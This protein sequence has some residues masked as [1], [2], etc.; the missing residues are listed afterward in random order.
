MKTRI[1]K[2]V[3]MQTLPG[4]RQS[5]ISEALATYKESRLPIGATG[6]GNEPCACCGYHTI[7]RGSAY[8]ICIICG[9]EDDGTP[10]EGYNDPFL[11]YDGPNHYSIHEYRVLFNFGYTAIPG[12]TVA[13]W[14]ALRRTKRGG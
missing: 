3:L 11:D 5:T 7:P 14:A 8:A 4:H 6:K 13:P 10:P 1:A 2:K 12:L 9:W